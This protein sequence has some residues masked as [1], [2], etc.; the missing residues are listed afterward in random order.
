[1]T[2]MNINGSSQPNINGGYTG[3]PTTTV[4]TAGP[5]A[6]LAANGTRPY[7][8]THLA[9][10]LGGY[11]ATRTCQL[12][13]WWAGGEASS[14]RESNTLTIPARDATGT[15]WVALGGGG[16]TLADSPGADILVG[17]FNSSGLM[18]FGRHGASGRTIVTSSGS[19]WPDQSL[20][21][22][23]LYVEAPAAPNAPTFSAITSSSAKASWTFTGDNGGESIAAYLVWIATDIN[24]T[25]NLVA[26]TVYTNSITFTGLVPNER[27]YVKVAA[28]NDLMLDM[29]TAGSWSAT[30]NFDTIASGQRFDATAEE[31]V[32]MT[33]AKRWTGTALVDLVT[34]KRWDGSAWVDFIN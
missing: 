6:R 11:G 31:F 21:G 30:R 33:I 29:S 12:A 15:G 22:Q 18:N 32:D 16:F 7:R 14:R 3:S 23:I 24:F 26:K 8:I 20:S 28:R 25:Q 13:A 17:Y 34:R 27:Y 2:V 4:K 19:D 5:T 9:M 1:M 10:F